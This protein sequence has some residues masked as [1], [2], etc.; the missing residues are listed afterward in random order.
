MMKKGFYI[1]L[2][3]ILCASLSGCW[4]RR[5]PKTIALIN[6]VIYDFSDTG[7][8]QITIEVINPAAQGG[9]TGDGSGKTP[10]ITAYGQ[11]NSMPEAIRNISES[12]E[13]TIFAGHI[14]VR[15]FSERFAQ[16]D[17][18]SAM[19]YIMRDYLTDENA[20]IIVIQ[21]GDPGQIYSCMLGLSEH[22]GDYITA[23]SET[24]P[25]ITSKSVFVKTLDFVKDY[26]KEGKQP[27][28]GVVRLVE[29]EAK[30]SKNT[31]TGSD[32]SQDSK[33]QQGG[34]DK[35]YRIIYG[36]LAAFKD[37][38]L[39]GYMDEV[40]A[41]AY[42][43]ITNNID[44]AVITIGAEDGQTA[45]IVHNSKAEV[46]TEIENGQ[47]TVDVKIKT[48]MDIVQEN[49]SLDIN[50]SE[51]LKKIEADYNK[52]MVEEI[53]AAIK[54]AQT[55]FQSD[56]FGFGV[57]MRKQHPQ[58][59]KEIKENW[60]DYFTNATINI[61]VESTVDRLGEFKQSFRWEFGK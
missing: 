58:K 6:S 55:E 43:F 34:S 24:Q 23:L 60:D 13:R 40:E 11:G 42:N 37:G 33:S 18:G 29:C 57:S 16:K 5:E 54:K 59:W 36:G 14:Q 2:C 30:P 56:I 4:S 38:K 39:A 10:N 19:D 46:K 44:R 41:R 31:E 12:L 9:T 35:N 51:I 32:N 27:V 17:I 3:I 8:C 61:S 47:V 1:V 26:Y 21:N 49:G 20:L 15:F 25:G 53:A 52:Q 50:E 45:V 48:Y 7:G 28:A 22:V